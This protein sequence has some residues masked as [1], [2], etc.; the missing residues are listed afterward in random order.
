MVV[1]QVFS[2][3]IKVKYKSTLLSKATLFSAI[4]CL[5]SLIVPYLIA[6]KTEGVFVFII[7]DFYYIWNFSGFWVK[8]L[9][10]HEQPKIDLKGEYLFVALTDNLSHPIICS[11]FLYYKEHLNFF[12]NCVFFRVSI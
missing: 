1:V 5:I 3:N 8:K 6:C 12:D 11:T 2:E 10:F 7:S 9:I 4:C